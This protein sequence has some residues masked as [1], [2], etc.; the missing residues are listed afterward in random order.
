VPPKRSY[1]NRIVRRRERLTTDRIF[2][3][4]APRADRA[5]RQRFAAT[6]WPLHD[7][8]AWLV[9]PH[10]ACTGTGTIPS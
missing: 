8:V 9:D 7:D 2:A 3:Y 1:P 6:Q 4:L 5:Q 10:G